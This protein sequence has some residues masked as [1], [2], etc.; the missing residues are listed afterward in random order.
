MKKKIFILVISL[1]IFSW[2]YSQSG[3]HSQ[4]KEGDI[5]FQVSKSKQSPLISAATMSQWTHCGIIVMKHNEPYVLEAS[6]TVKLTPWKQW[7]EHGKGSITAMKR[8]TEQ[9]ITI[10]YKQYLG[11]RYDLAFKFNN[12]KWYCSELVYDIYLKQHK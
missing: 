12:N 3:N 2:L 7:K 1:I 11:K 5:V 8:Y 4:L 9:P 10:N 6:S